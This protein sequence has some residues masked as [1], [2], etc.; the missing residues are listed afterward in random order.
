MSLELQSTYCADGAQPLVIGYSVGAVGLRD[1]LLVSATV[2]DEYVLLRF[3]RLGEQVDALKPF[4][5]PISVQAG[6]DESVYVIQRWG[7]SDAIVE[8]YRVPA[9]EEGGAADDQ[10]GG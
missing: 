1:G 6:S 3:N 8:R 9:L 2:A 7:Q 4:Y 10:D 5:R